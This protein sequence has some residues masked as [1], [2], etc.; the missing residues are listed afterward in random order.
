MCNFST[1]EIIDLSESSDIDDTLYNECM[2]KTDN[3][4]VDVIL[5]LESQVCFN[6]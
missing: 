3:L 5:D 4:G 1:D 6:G 2:K